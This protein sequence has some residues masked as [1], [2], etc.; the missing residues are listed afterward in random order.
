MSWN[1]RVVKHDCEEDYYEVVEV[2]YDKEGNINGYA[3]TGCPYGE[4][5]EGIKRC[6]GL[7][8][9]ALDEPILQLS[10]FKNIPSKMCH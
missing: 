9:K 10:G 1:Y 3:D 5:L 7:I 8:S 6:L 4:S 2:Y